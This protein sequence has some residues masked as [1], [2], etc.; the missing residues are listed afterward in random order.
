VPNVGFGELL[1][2][3]L[4]ALLVF[5][6]KKLPE[7]GKTLGKSLREFRQTAAQVRAELDMEEEP[8]R[9]PMPSVAKKQAAEAAGQDEEEPPPDPAGSGTETHP[10]S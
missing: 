10:A 7:I 9:V 6:P 5:G 4:F 1:V 8:P 3:L 2:L